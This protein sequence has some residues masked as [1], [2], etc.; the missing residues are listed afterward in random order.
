ML[1]IA[2]DTDPNIITPEEKARLEKL[3]FND[4]IVFGEGITQENISVTLVGSDVVIT[5][6]ENDSLTIKNATTSNSSVENIQLSDGTILKIKDLQNATEFNDNLTFGNTSVTL[7]ALGG[8]DRVTTGSS[9]NDIIFSFLSDNYNIKQLQKY[10][11]EYNY[12]Y[13][14]QNTFTKITRQA[15]IKTYLYIQNS[16]EFNNNKKEVA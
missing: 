13:F 3:G 8:D 14:T 2:L 5:L 10:T 11:I 9:G 7:D 12:N 4:T 15:N 16:L 6:N 1:A